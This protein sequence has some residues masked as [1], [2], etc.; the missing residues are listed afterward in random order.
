MWFEHLVVIGDGYFTIHVGDIEDENHQIRRRDLH[1]QIK[2]LYLGEDLDDI[3]VLTAA[4]EQRNRRLHWDISEY[5]AYRELQ[6]CVHEIV[7][8]ALLIVLDDEEEEESSGDDADD[9][10]E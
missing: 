10:V 6:G 4:P 1:E 8:E 5:N 3:R 2:S 7:S 9:N